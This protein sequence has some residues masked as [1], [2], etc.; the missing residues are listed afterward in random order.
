M[1]S[2]W[3]T[4]HRYIKLYAFFLSSCLKSQL[5]YR[6]N[7][8]IR[9]FYG[10]AYVGVV[11]LVLLLA[12]RQVNSLAGWNKNELLLLFGI[13]S[14]MYNIAFTLYVAPV[15]ILLSQGIRAGEVD[16]ALTK[17][18]SAQFSLLLSKPELNQVFMLAALAVFSVYKLWG[19][20]DLL[21]WSGT[22]WFVVF[23]IAGQLTSYFMIVSYA[24]LG[25]VLIRARQVI[26][27][28]DKLTDYSHY[29][30][31]IFPKSIQAIA[32]T[33]VPFALYGYI[34][35]AFLLGRGENWLMGISLFSLLGSYAL[36]RWAWEAGLRRYSSVSS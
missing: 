19:L 31:P 12:T 6:W 1:I 35:T 7:F 15:K 23:L 10:P 18:V 16:V 29:P 32:F 30:P 25:F 14:F 20:K 24:S 13:S 8:F 28:Y 36:S 5:S 9:L 11:F 34:P 17:P 2:I 33:V 27:V 3:S 26:E 22:G 21:S 4:C